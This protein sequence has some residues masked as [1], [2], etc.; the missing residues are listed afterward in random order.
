MR[1]ARA[2]FRSGMTPGDPEAT[3]PAILKVVDAAEPPLR[4]FFGSAGLG[5][6]SAEYARRIETWEAWNDVSRRGPGRP[7]GPPGG[8]ILRLHEITGPTRPL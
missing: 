5:M 8:V 7:G 6:T 2:Q 4:V 3:G 1:A